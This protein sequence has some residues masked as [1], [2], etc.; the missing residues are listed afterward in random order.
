MRLLSS[1]EL[2]PANWCPRKDLNLYLSGFEADASAVGLLGPLVP[3][4][5]FEPTLDGFLDRFLCRWD[6]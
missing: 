5:G 4:V 3:M 6:T 1:P 2:Y